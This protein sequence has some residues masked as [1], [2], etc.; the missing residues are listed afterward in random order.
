MNNV[1]VR[2][3]KIRLKASP[4]VKHDGNIIIEAML[5]SS[6]YLFTNSRASIHEET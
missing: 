5:Q 1:S 3:T 2:D 6:L 4:S